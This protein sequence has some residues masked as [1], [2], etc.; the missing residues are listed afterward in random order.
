[1]NP[2]TPND[3]KTQKWPLRHWCLVADHFPIVVRPSAPRVRRP[4]ITVCSRPWDRVD[5]DE[6]SSDILNADWSSFYAADNVNDKLA[7]FYVYL[8]HCG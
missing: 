3:P 2:K 7:I 4:P 6:F 8:G 5:W 1:M